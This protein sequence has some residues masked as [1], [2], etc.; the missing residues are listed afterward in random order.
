MVTLHLKLYYLG[1]VI[2]YHLGGS[3]R[4]CRNLGNSH[5]FQVKG[6]GDKSLLQS[7]EMVLQKIDCQQGRGVEGGGSQEGGNQVTLVVT[8]P[9]SPTTSFLQAMTSPLDKVFRLL[10]SLSSPFHK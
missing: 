4:V 6:R 3:G 1:Q 8:Q 5:G 2:V 7:I 9:K 10:M